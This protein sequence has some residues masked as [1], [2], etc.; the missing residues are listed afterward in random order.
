MKGKGVTLFLVRKDIKPKVPPKRKPIPKEPLHT[1]VK[2]DIFLAFH[3][4]DFEKFLE[5]YRQLTTCQNC[6]KI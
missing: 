3:I 2:M 5:T 1:E 6:D 4:D